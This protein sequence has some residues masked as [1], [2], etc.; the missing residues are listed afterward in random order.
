M[1]AKLIVVALLLVTLG[2]YAQTTQDA[3]PVNLLIMSYKGQNMP[4]SV[5]DCAQGAVKVPSPCK[6]DP[7]AQGP[8]AAAIM[9][10]Y[11]DGNRVVY[12]AVP[13]TDKRTGNC[14]AQ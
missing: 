7:N 6:P 2:L 13:C 12:M 8:K 1:K 14:L 9:V 11:A 4:I 5:A 3:M 10:E